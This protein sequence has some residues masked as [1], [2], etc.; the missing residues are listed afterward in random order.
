MIEAEGEVTD[1]E[2]LVTLI[3]TLTVMI[4]EVKSGW[5]DREHLPAG[6]LFPIS[7]CLV[8]PLEALVLFFLI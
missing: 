8:R 7:S 5:P 4:V 1:L 3:D 2:N 6:A